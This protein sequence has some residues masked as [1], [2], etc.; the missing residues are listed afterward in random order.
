MSGAA[1][2]T[3]RSFDIYELDLCPSCTFDVTDSGLI[4][5][6]AERSALLSQMQC[7]STNLKM[8]PETYFPPEGFCCFN[9]RMKR[10]NFAIL[11]VFFSRIDGFETMCPDDLLPSHQ[12]IPRAISGD[13]VG[14]RRHMPQRFGYAKERIARSVT[15]LVKGMKSVALA[16]KMRLSD[17]CFDRPHSKE[18][19]DRR[20]PAGERSHPFSSTLHAAFAGWQRCDAP[21]GCD[22]ERARYGEDDRSRH[23]QGDEVAGV[24][25]DG[26]KK[27]HVTAPSCPGMCAAAAAQ[28][29]AHAA[30]RR[31]AA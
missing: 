4:H 1:K 8:E 5:D 16:Q 6:F 23:R 19:S 29:S 3:E 15:G 12:V 26:A 11:E 17:L 14:G 22:E 2:S 7:C 21:A 9:Y 31:A 25:R 30:E 13:C 10:L 28:W 27:P 20:H 24:A 18:R